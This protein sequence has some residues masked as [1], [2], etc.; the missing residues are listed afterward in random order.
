MSKIKSYTELE[1]EIKKRLP[2]KRFIHSKGVADTSRILS[3]HFSLPSDAAMICG[4]YHDAYRY[5]SLEEALREVDAFSIP[6]FNEERES[7]NLLHAPIA[8]YHMPFDV[9]PVP[10]SW[11]RA[12]RFHTLGSKEM[13]KLGA[14][15]YIADYMEP[16]RKHLDDEER[17]KIFSLPTLET[18]VRYIIEAQ[19]VYFREKGIKN[20]AVTDELYSFLCKGGCFAS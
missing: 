16:N 12:V 20:A 1:I 7:V 8:A 15:L 11:C 13:G 6:V 17:R 5:I 18:M 19:N 9:G 2:L 4:I 10:E 3:E 14:V